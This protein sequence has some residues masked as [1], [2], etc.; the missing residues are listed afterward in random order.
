MRRSIAPVLALLFAVTAFASEDTYRKGFNVADGGTLRLE[1]VGNV[2]VV[3]G[4]TGVAVEVRADD[5]IQ[6]IL[7]DYKITF[8]Q[9]GNDVVIKSNRNWDRSWHLFDWDDDDLQ[10]NIRVPAHYNVDLDTSGGWIDLADI[11]G[12]TK[13]RTSGGSIKAG[14][15]RGEA[16]LRTSGGSITVNGATAKLDVY[17]S[18]GS[19]DIGDTNGPVQAKTSGGSI[20]LGRVAGDVVARTS[21]GGIKIEDALGSVD[22]S[23]SGGS[24]T[25][26]MS[27]QPSGDS[28]LSTSGGRVTVSLA[29][30]IAVDLDARASGGGVTSDV[31]V[32][33]QGT[34]EEDALRGAVNGGGPKLVLRTS[35]GGIR[36]KSL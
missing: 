17:T 27:R 16:N 23:T 32:T 30:S 25:A 33:V 4:G 12:T 7:R 22:A 14:Q 35:G 13:A 29:P 18:G 8:A 5:D 3:V 28:R 2:K 34:Q 11:G 6:K 36:V 20:S 15:L 26:R 24:I 19:I 21:G 1:V 31:P 10:W 9:D